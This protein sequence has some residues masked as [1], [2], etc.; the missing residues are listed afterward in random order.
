MGSRDERLKNQ[1][2]RA[3]E[4]AMTR[5]NMLEFSDELTRFLDR[6]IDIE[7]GT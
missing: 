3:P 1:A 5:D 2:P 4:R 7:A 6:P